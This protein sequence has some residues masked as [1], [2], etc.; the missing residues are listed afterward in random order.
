VTVVAAATQEKAGGSTDGDGGPV[1]IAVSF[2]GLEPFF[3]TAE[4]ILSKNALP[5]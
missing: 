3:F 2:S 1:N 4:A 5:A